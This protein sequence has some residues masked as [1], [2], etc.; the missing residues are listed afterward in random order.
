MHVKN[1]TYMKEIIEL[2]NEMSP[3]LLLGFIFAGIMHAFL[4]KNFFHRILGGKSIKSVVNATLLGIPVP[5]CS[6]GT[7]PTAMS[8]RKDGASKGATISFLTVTPQT[9]IDSFIAT[10][11]IIG[12][13]F[14]LMRIVSAFVTS[15][16]AGI[17]VTKYDDNGDDNVTDNVSKT[18]T[19]DCCNGSFLEKIKTAIRY[20]FVE[21]MQDIGKWLIIG[22][23]IAGIITVYVPDSFFAL[24]ADSPL[25]SMLLVLLFSVPMYTCATGSIPIAAALIMK[26]LSPGTALVLLMAGPAINVASIFVVNKV[27]GKKTTMIYLFS[28]IFGAVV[29]G[30]ITDYLLPAE[31]FTSTI[32]KIK[33]CCHEQSSIFNQMCTIV[34]IL[35]L[36]NAFRLRGKKHSCCCKHTGTNTASNDISIIVEGMKCN[37]CKANLEK[38][39][40]EIDGIEKVNIDITTGQVIISGNANYNEINKAVESLGFT[41]K[42]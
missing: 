6:C 12:F 34:M 31:W 32:K 42:A 2:V 11:S 28:I 22:L 5:L 37:H 29:F 23:V 36:A 39:L 1:K 21:M 18:N 41:I 19:S 35:L 24:F 15:L 38:S 3:Y 8:L 40:Y 27:L 30:L 14:A 17:L 4:P 20:A 16:I 33:D 10:Y 26:G 13:P 25:L 9:G 7:I